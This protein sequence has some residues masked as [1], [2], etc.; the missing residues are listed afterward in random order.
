VTGRPKGF[1]LVELLVVMTIIATLLMIAVP[2]Y[3]RSLEQAREVT[4]RQDLSVM[5]DAIDKFL[6]DRGTYPQSLEDLVEGKYLRS[7]PVDPYT[8]STGSWMPVQSEDKELTGVRDV[9][10]G[11]EGVTRDGTALNEI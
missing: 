9:H 11:A 5:R 3:H 4:L 2:R 7:I 10:S 8:K 1:T 6:A